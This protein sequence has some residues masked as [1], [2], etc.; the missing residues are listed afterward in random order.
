MSSATGARWRV[1]RA[2]TRRDGAAIVLSSKGPV[3]EDSHLCAP[4]QPA[5]PPQVAAPEPRPHSLPKSRGL[6]RSRE[7]PAAERSGPFQ[8]AIRYRF[9][10]RRHCS[11][12]SPHRGRGG[13]RGG[14]ADA[15]KSEAA[16]G[17]DGSQQQPAEPRRDTH[18][19]EPEKPP[20]SSANGVKMYCL[21]RAAGREGGR[22]GREAR[23]A[24]GR[25]QVRCWRPRP[26]ARGKTVPFK[27]PEASLILGEDPGMTSSV[28]SPPG[29]VPS[30]G[31]G[32]VCG[33]GFQSVRA[34]RTH[35]VPLDWLSKKED[36]VSSTHPVMVV[37]R[38]GWFIY[39][40]F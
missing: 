37:G 31:E 15:D 12:R 2:S 36:L 9:S 28:L 40:F 5:L 11:A 25:E 27:R 14:M 38:A 3:P 35:C 24:P 7:I 26:R 8:I 39:S 16:A 30:P 18:P 21:P 23:A 19:G 13:A 6:V 17:D 4:R 29:P 20:R 1:R 32:R 10:G 33:G 22:A 34:H